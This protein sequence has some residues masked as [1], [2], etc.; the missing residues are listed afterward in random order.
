MTATQIIHVDSTYRD[1]LLYPNPADF[2][3]EYGSPTTNGDDM[4]K[5]RNPVTNQ[6]PIYN[7]VFPN[8]VG[9]SNSIDFLSLGYTV[10]NSSLKIGIS[11]GNQ[12]AII[13][14]ASDM[15]NIFG[16]SIMR[17]SNDFLS[18]LNFV[19][20]SSAPYAISRIISFDSL[21][22]VI[23]L[24]NPI[25]IDLTTLTYCYIYNDSF[26]TNDDFSIVF[27][28]RS[29]DTKNYIRLS[30]LFL[31]NA[32]TGEELPV[33]ITPDERFII[34]IDR[35]VSKVF[36]NWSVNDF[37]LL[38]LR[39][40]NIQMLKP[41]GDGNYSSR[42]IRRLHLLDSTP[43]FTINNSVYH[44]YETNTGRL[45][46][47]SL[48]ITKIDGSGRIVSFD[49]VSRGY[50]INMNTT[51]YIEDFGV[52]GDRLYASFAIQDTYQS[53]LIPQKMTLQ[54]NT[55]FTPFAF[56]PLFKHDDIYNNDEITFNVFPNE[57]ETYM[58]N[59]LTSYVPQIQ[60][61]SGSA[62]IYDY[63]NT[64]DGETII[65]TT[66]YDESTLALL[67]KQYKNNWWNGVMLSVVS[68]DQ[69]V[70]LNYSGS[71][72]SQSQLNCYEI[73]LL[74]LILPNLEL[75]TTQVLTSFFPYL[76]VELSNATTVSRNINNLYTNNQF[77]QS[78]LFAVPISDVNS[79]ETSQFL[80][81]SNAGMTQIAKF[82][83]NDSLHFRVFL[84]NGKTFTPTLKDTLLPM[85]PSAL[86]QISAIFSIRK[87]D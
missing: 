17:E 16:V 10:A 9:Y 20:G 81:L 56:T 63:Y 30:G 3:V 50:D 24:E 15:V 40:T 74:N 22:N 67:Q 18:N 68:Q 7:F 46:T 72:V 78:A 23:T 85:I 19:Y 66:S 29:L 65:Y 86:V 26:V 11:G 83:P 1:R 79:P 55:F 57:Y 38:F 87:I 43:L 31:Y 4:F 48:T 80:N 59:E 52:N 33:R 49:M 28:G 54:K 62:M 44:L 60:N 2:V 36:S 64:D 35:F 70:P 45:S 14:D 39:S 82:K 61:A 6:L 41:F 75:N 76:F 69:F 73:K 37:Y 12:N 21:T 8:V 71:T 34:P 58:N 42:S 27:S 84:T 53:F 25:S 47:I 51:Y 32:T 5:M 13:L 77:G